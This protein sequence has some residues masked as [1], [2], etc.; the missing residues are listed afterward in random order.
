MSTV[1]HWKKNFLR[2][3]LS[4]QDISFTFQMMLHQ[5]K[6]C[7]HCPFGFLEES[8]DW[9]KFSL[10]F[11][12]SKLFLF[13]KTLIMGHFTSLPI[14][15]LLCK[16]RTQYTFFDL[17]CKSAA[18]TKFSIIEFIKYARKIARFI[19]TALKTFQVSLY[20]IFLMINKK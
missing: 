14:P 16:D 2:V 6:Y 17:P 4:Y 11:F 19:M 5:T 13:A 9:L 1:K 3:E 18:N 20:E 7:I 12:V 15:F 10:N 8:Q